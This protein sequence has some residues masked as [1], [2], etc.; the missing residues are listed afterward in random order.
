MG[1]ARW[2]KMAHPGDLSLTPKA[3]N[4]EANN[5]F[6]LPSGPKCM[7]W[8]EHSKTQVENIKNILR[9]GNGTIMN[10]TF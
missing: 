7:A 2:L 4:L 10:L 8:Q 3:H 1:V 6:K 5:L 9:E